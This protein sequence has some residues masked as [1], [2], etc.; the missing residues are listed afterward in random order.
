MQIG[1]VGLGDL[2]SWIANRLIA[3]KLGPMAVFDADPQAMQRYEQSEVTLAQ[4]L[5]DVGFTSADIVGVCVV[6]DA[7]TRDVVNGLLAGPMRPGSVIAVHSTVDPETCREL[8]TQADAAGVGLMDAGISKSGHLVMV[9]ANDST[10]ARA[11][12]YLKGIGDNVEH[13][14]QVGSGEIVKLIVNLLIATEMGTAATV[15]SCCE[16]LGV[17]RDQV[18]RSLLTTDGHRGIRTLQAT[19]DRA[20]LVHR[21]LGKDVD[22]ATDVLSRGGCDTSFLRAA[23]DAGLAAVHANISKG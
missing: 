23:S 21:L 2:G 1:F 19:A 22:T 4:G 5:T 8:C 9:G 7:Q 12:P 15:L 10:F 18:I 3:S 13:A 11:L 16:Q 14:G 17:N 20:A 6:N